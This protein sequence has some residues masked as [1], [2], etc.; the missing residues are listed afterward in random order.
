[1]AG[2]TADQCDGVPCDQDW[3]EPCKD[4][5]NDFLQYWLG[6]YTR[7]DNGGFADDGSL[8]RF[9]GVG[10]PLAGFTG[11]LDGPESA[12]NQA[13]GG[14]GPATH[15]ITSSVLAPDTHPD[16]ASSPGASWEGAGQ[17]TARTGTW[18]MHSQVIDQAYKRLTKTIDL[19]GATSGALDFQANWNTEEDW[20]WFL[21]EAHTVGQS[22]WTTLPDANGHTSHNTGQSCPA[23]DDYFALHP[24]VAHYITRSGSGTDADPWVCTSGGTTGVWNVASG[25]SAG[26][27][28]WHLDLSAFAG[29]QVEV[30]IT[31]I[32]D[33]SFGEIPGVL[34][35][36]VSVTRGAA[37]ETT[38]FE[39]GTGGWTVP[40][41][42]A[43]SF[44]GNDWVRTQRAYEEGAVAKTADS[45]YFGFGFEGVAGAAARNDL[46]RR[47][48]HYLLR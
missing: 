24:F 26:Y 36:D 10:D 27:E 19:T 40:G 17:F 7:A 47:S 22:D 16:F 9:A 31:L 20:D 43:G 12:D 2:A 35:D 45:L 11:S 25:G 14:L 44:N 48:M 29:K 5:S 30:S 23:G 38:S 37:V 15:L 13:A 4:L 6:S 42:P 46:M 8:L 32:S 34:L 39:D 18:F 28:P 41:A 33:W 3:D 21:V 1:V